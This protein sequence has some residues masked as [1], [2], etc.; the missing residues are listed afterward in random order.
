VST[1][2]KL[3]KQKAVK[4]SVQRQVLGGNPRLEQLQELDKQNPE[5]VHMYQHPGVITG[6]KK[7]EWD[8]ESKGQEVVKDEDGNVL[9]HMGDPVVRVTMAQW[10]EERAFEAQLSRSE[11]E[12]V[13]KPSRST[14]ERNPKKVPDLET[15]KE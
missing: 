5:Y 12:S 8:A 13:V 11:V 15:K 9:H 6:D 2:A 4:R 7:R 3:P 1:E 10:K 14:F